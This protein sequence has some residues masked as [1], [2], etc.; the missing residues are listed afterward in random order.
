MTG[1]EAFKNYIIKVK[2]LCVIDCHSHFQMG[3]QVQ[4]DAPLA[5][6]EAAIGAQMDG[7]PGFRCAEM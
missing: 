6:G 7:R 1:P 2:P 5:G 3:K 4:G